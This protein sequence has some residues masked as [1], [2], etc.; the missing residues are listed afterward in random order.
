MG[1][2]LSIW[3]LPF[4]TMGA[5]ILWVLFDHLQTQRTRRMHRHRPL[6]LRAATPDLAYR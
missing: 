5:P 6:P 2:M 1:S 3:L 4:W